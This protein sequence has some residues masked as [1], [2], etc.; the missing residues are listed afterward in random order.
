[1]RS[2][3]LKILHGEIFIQR[4]SKMGYKYIRVDREREGKVAKLTFN[5]P[6]KLNAFHEP[7]TRE[8][9]VALQEIANDPKVMV[10]IMTGAGGNFCAGDDIT[11]ITKTE[12]QDNMPKVRFYQSM[13]NLIEEM[14]KI[15]IAAVE[16]YALGGGLELTMVCDLVF[17]EEGALF[18]T[19]EIDIDVIPGWGGTQRYARLIGRRKVKEMLFLGNLLNAQEAKKFQLVNYVMPKDKLYEAVNDTIDILLDKNPL[20][21]KL[22]KFV[23]TRGIEADL[24]TGLGFEVLGSTICTADKNLRNA[25]AE[26]AKHGGSWNVRRNRV[27]AWMKKYQGYSYG[28]P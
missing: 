25:T 8:L 18:G 14:D 6:E 16:G 23:I 1:M 12:I 13:S 2:S 19:P 3:G 5:Q 4:R 26:F 7:L 15:T 21:L 24:M 22:G 20:T 17:A 10:M 28:K 9:M 11:E 27:K